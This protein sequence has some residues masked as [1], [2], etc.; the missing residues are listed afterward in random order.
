MLLSADKSV[1]ITINI[2][3]ENIISAGRMINIDK[4]M[5]KD[6]CNI[7]K[8][9]VFA[10]PTGIFFWTTYLEIQDFQNKADLYEIIFKILLENIFKIC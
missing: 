8:N 4:L 3:K 10:K 2:K 6:I 7:I 9:S 1:K 5:N